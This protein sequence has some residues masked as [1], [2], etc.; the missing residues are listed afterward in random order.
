MAIWAA[1]WHSKNQVDG[2]RT[3]IL[4]DNCLPALFRTRQ[5]AREF[6]KLRY[7][8]IARSS[9][10]R[11]EPYGWRVPRAVKVNVAPLGE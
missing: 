6:I 4:C 5:A 10:L 2:E 11:I 8:Y 7:G 1:Q 9:D 3:Y